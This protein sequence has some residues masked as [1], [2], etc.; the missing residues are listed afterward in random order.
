MS[1][2]ITSFIVMS[3]IS[4]IFGIGLAFAS[5][6]LAVK[7]DERVVLLKEALPG[8]NCGACGFAGCQDYANAIIFHNA[9]LNKC[10]PGGKETSEKISNIMGVSA[11]ISE[12]MVAKVLCIGGYQEASSSKEYQG[13]KTCAAANLTKSAKD[14]PFGCLGFGDCTLVCPFDAIHMNNNGLPV[15][16]EDKCTG[17][18]LCVKACPRNI[19]ELA[20]FSAY[21]TVNCRSKDRGPVVQKYCKV[22][23]IGCGICVKACNGEGIYMENNLAIVDYKAY[24]GDGTPAVKCPKKTI[25]F[26]QAKYEKM[27]KV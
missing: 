16:D 26:Q 25:V 21:L 6:K 13:I 3:L 27:I 23:C 10:S 11:Q 14:C 5:N 7:V 20:P 19:I 4:F 18:G 9:P 1:I 24:K 12:K 15:V 2:M 17:C 22:G 8:I